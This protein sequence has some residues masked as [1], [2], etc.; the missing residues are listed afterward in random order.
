MKKYILFFF[1]VLTAGAAHAQGYRVTL[2]APGYKSG[3]T[4]L[5][6]YMGNNF[7]IADSAAI[8]TNGV[9]VFKGPVNLQPG[10]YAIFFPGKQLRTEFLINKEQ[11]I[12]VTADTADLVNKTKVTGSKEN[13]LYDQYQKFAAARG[14]LMQRE[15]RAYNNATTPADSLLHEKNY[16][17]YNKELNDYREGIIKNQP[18]SMMAALLNA[19][20]EPAY[21]A[22]IPVTKQDSIDNYNE[23]V[24][25]YWNGITFMDDRIIRTPF[26]LKKLE[27]YYR[28]VISPDA[29]SIIKDVDYKLLLARSAP[30]MYKFLLNWLTD[31]FI[32]PRYMGQD[33][34]FVHLFDKYHSKGLSSWLNE[35]QMEAISRRAYMLM[36]NLIGEKA[37]PLEMLDTADMPASLYSVDAD[38][39]IICF[40]DPNC[41]HCREEIPRLD[42]LYRASWKNHQVKIFAVLTPDGKKNVKPEWINFI[43]EQHI[44]DWTHVYITKEMEDAEYAAQKPGFRQLYDITSTPVIYLLDKEKRIIGKKLTLLQLHELLQVKWSAAAN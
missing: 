35:K 7:N 33:A 31:N 12:S 17:T 2:H 3:I 19:M 11:V 41:G 4:Y 37:A 14:R 43:K 42:S 40:W 21:P 30:E 36:A 39:T 20:K 15:R 23:Y 32:S 5:T 34:V 9:A 38:Y 10:I 22:K 6:Y 16:N 1:A 18:N 26:F 24:K 8:G 44:G 29:E 25:N 28:E 13:I 27:R